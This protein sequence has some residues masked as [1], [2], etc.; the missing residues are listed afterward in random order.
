M[1]KIKI[2][3]L[4]HQID[5]FIHLLRERRI[6]FILFDKLT[7]DITFILFLLLLSK[8][9]FGT[10]FMVSLSTYVLDYCL[11]LDDKDNQN[12]EEE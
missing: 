1:C 4:F 10:I 7:I 3:I 5:Y 6:I 11:K 2:R 8:M 9:L 12:E